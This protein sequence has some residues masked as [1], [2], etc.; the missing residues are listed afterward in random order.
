MY[1]E[2][3]RASNVRRRRRGRL[4]AAAFVAL[5]TTLM[6]AS[7]AQA[8]S[9]H[10]AGPR[11]RVDTATPT[12]SHPTR[13]TNPLFPINTTRQMIATGAEGDVA[14]R[15][16]TTLLPRTRTIRVNGHDVETI[17]S[18][19]V[20]HGDGAIKE[21]AIDYFAQADDGSVWYFGEDVKT[22]ENGLVKSTAG[23]W[24]AEPAH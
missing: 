24:R 8:L 7:P 12:F 20:A 23:T 3:I 19:F 11:G 15:Q 9:R 13:I 16:E 6:L 5:P 21:V 17:V 14:L 18:Q 22:Y 4:V 2:P 1:A 10:S